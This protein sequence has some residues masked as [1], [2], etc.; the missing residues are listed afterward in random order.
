MIMM[1]AFPRF[2][3]SFSRLVFQDD[4]RLDVTA[5]PGLITILDQALYRSVEGELTATI[6]ASHA[7]LACWLDLK[8]QAQATL[9][10]SLPPKLESLA[11]MCLDASCDAIE[12]LS[13]DKLA[14][15]A[16]LSDAYETTGS[17]SSTGILS[18]QISIIDSLGD[19][20]RRLPK[21]Q[22]SRDCW[23]TSR[24]ICPDHVWADDAYL[25]CQR[26]LRHLSKCPIPTNI[27][28]EY[29]S[30]DIKLLQSLVQQDIPVRLHQFRAAIETNSSITKRLY[31]VKC[32]YRAP[33]R[34][35]LEAHQTVQRAPSLKLVESYISGEETKDDTS[36]QSLL[37][38][39]ELIEALS[40]EEHL[41][42]LETNMAQALYGFTEL[43][44]FLDHKRARI[45][46]VS[47]ILEEDKV[48][49][50]QNLVRHLKVCNCRKSGPETSTGI[51]PLLLD[52]QGVR[53]DED[54]TKDTR[55]NEERIKIFLD[56]L[57]TLNQ[58]CQTRNAFLL[59]KRGD[60]DL[61]PSIT[62]E[63]TKFDA[64]LWQAYCDDWF[65]LVVRQ[66]EIA[67]DFSNLQDLIR[68]AEMS[69]SI[70]AA[71]K[72]SLEVVRQ[73]LELI[74]QD[75][76]KRFDVLK[77]MVEEVCWREMN[78]YIKVMEPAEDK[79]LKLPNTKVLGLLGVHLQMA[80]ET[81]PIG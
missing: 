20:G 3:N 42:G 1:H 52:L 4:F 67:K 38:T 44:R 40:L 77:E 51:R 28:G 25:T 24:L 54:V 70:K 75:R 17:F 68:K 41:E 73:R 61:P 19:T 60:L 57:N 10:F 13:T 11:R 45:K 74:S 18:G 26:L 55:T 65:E 29:W 12:K 69:I 39:P 6:C 33:F 22:R 78:L 43:A 9:V 21:L 53:R 5:A 16:N 66:H 46:A 2:L 34:A 64:E 30:H 62:K 36:L 80:G 63:C 27:A 32:E 7:L 37:D 79:V 58:L 76:Q 56:Q 72:K 47:Q 35:F 59:E 48:K 15:S 81:L 71:P 49:D 23:E 50:V 8:H 31:L 14:Q